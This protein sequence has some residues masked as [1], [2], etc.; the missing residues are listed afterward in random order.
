V[1]II[2]MSFKK[3][4]LFACIVSG[5][6]SEIYYG[7]AF[8]YGFVVKGEVKENIVAETLST[9]DIKN[10]PQILGTNWSVSITNLDS[11]IFNGSTYITKNLTITPLSYGHIHSFYFYP[12]NASNIQGSMTNNRID[13]I[14]DPDVLSLWF[15]AQNGHIS[16]DFSDGEILSVG[17]VSI[18]TDDVELTT[19]DPHWDE[20]TLST[21]S[22]AKMTLTASN[23]SIFWFSARVLPDLIPIN[24]TLTINGFDG[25]AVH[26]G[27]LYIGGKISVKSSSMT[28]KTIDRPFIG[29]WHQF[30]WAHEPEYWE[31]AIYG[32]DDVRI[33]GFCIPY[34]SVGV[35]ICG[36]ASSIILIILAIIQK[37]GIGNYDSW[38]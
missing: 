14:G 37:S 17:Y 21:K 12:D 26:N 3:I 5:I 8:G 24:G 20:I 33:E 4:V 27:F 15:Y 28:I 18:K 38:S 34:W 2:R 1:H 10:N 13:S 32:G 31:I 36:C 25:I 22:I 7:R 16:A 6:V 35:L 29:I 30:G 9:I 19:T 23:G 11:I